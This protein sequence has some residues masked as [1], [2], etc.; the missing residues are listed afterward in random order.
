MTI[1]NQDEYVSPSG[2]TV[3]IQLNV[4]RMIWEV[5]CWNEDDSN[6]WYLVFKNKEE[7]FK[8]FNRWRT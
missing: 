4:E 6:H 8:E 5:A 1:S 2:Q 3:S 7:A